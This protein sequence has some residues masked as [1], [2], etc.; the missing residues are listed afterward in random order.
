MFDISACLL[1]SRIVSWLS[2]KKRVL[3]SSREENTL[4]VGKSEMA[5]QRTAKFHII[6]YLYHDAKAGLLRGNSFSSGM[7]CCGPLLSRSRPRPRSHGRILPKSSGTPLISKDSFLNILEQY[8]QSNTN[9]YI[10]QTKISRLLKGFWF[11]PHNGVQPQIDPRNFSLLLHL[12]FLLEVTLVMRV[13]SILDHQ[14]ASVSSTQERNSDLVVQL[15]KTA[16]A[17]MYGTSHH[18]AKV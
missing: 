17:P 15:G 18:H 14:G 2:V 10:Y 11:P 6:V 16:K 3:A 7:T 12:L 13:S 4:R 8:E 5:T 1:S 9:T